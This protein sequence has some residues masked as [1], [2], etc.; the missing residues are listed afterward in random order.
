MIHP[1]LLGGEVSHSSCARGSAS[2]GAGAAGVDCQGISQAAVAALTGVNSPREPGS[3][4]VDA[5]DTG[6]MSGHDEMPM[7]ELAQSDVSA[8]LAYIDSFAPPDGAMCAHEHRCA[9]L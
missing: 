9:P 1:S 6:V 7:F 5:Q 2:L 4:L 3:V 8:L